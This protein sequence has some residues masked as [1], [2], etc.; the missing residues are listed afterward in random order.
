MILPCD[1]PRVAALRR[2]RSHPFQT[3]ELPDK[4]IATYGAYVGIDVR[5]SSSTPVLSLPLDAALD[6]LD[7]ARP[8]ES[9]AS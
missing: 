2:A 6:R 9:K 1:W 7:I 3:R 4:W 5:D 8:M